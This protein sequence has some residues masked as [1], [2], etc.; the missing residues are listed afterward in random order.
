MAHKTCDRVS[1]SEVIDN[2][3]S[4]VPVVRLDDEY[5]QMLNPDDVTNRCEITAAE[6]TIDRETASRDGHVTGI[7]IIM[8]ILIIITTTI[9][10]K[11]MLVGCL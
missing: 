6:A 8:M 4:A 11:I 2:N 10:K 3:N 7:I 5:I 9:I 1:C